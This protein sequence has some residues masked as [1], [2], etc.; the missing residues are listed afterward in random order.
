MSWRLEHEWYAEEPM[1][2]REGM[3][4]GGCDRMRKCRDEGL[5]GHNG[6]SALLPEEQRTIYSL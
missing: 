6:D 2:V 5:K 1:Q 4:N 3:G